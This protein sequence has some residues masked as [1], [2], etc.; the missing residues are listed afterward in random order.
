VASEALG[1]A[2]LDQTP[3]VTGNDL[4]AALDT[5]PRRRPRRLLEAA[6]HAGP[7]PS[8]PAWDWDAAAPSTAEHSELEQLRAA[9]ERLAGE[10]EEAH[11]AAA[12]AHAE[13]QRLREAVSELASTGFWQRR[14]VVAELRAAALLD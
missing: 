14:R 11:A 1:M 3:H 6:P 12:R 10:L 7:Q 2:E 4:R 8:Q 13:E 9:V 5:L